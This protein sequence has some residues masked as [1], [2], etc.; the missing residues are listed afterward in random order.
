MYKVPVYRGL[1][2]AHRKHNLLMIHL[3]EKQRFRE[4]KRRWRE[5]PTCQSTHPHGHNNWQCGGS[6]RPQPGLVC[7]LQEPQHSDCPPLPVHTDHQ[8]AGTWTAL[9]WHPGTAFICYTTMLVLKML[10]KKEKNA[11]IFHQNIL[12]PLLK[13][14][15]IDPNK[16]LFVH[17]WTN[18]SADALAGNWMES[19]EAGAQTNAQR[20][21]QH[22]KQQYFNTLHHECPPQRKF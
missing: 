5:T 12:F 8:A 17:Y 6:A 21:W 19:R 10:I 11:W 3:V 18:Q 16:E 14:P 2:R 22:C 9:I 7:G 15:H 1:Q 13:H 20:R 4:R